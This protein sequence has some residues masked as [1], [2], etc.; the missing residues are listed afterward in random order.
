MAPR[1]A[2]SDALMGL[3]GIKRKNVGPCSVRGD[4]D[5]VDELS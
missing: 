1:S 4:L 2:V 5:L 3:S